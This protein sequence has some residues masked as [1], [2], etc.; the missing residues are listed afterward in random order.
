MRKILFTAS[1]LFLLPLTAMGQDTPG[2]EVFGGFSYLHTEGGGNLYGW[3]G[4][5]NVNLNKWFGLVVDFSGHYDSSSSRSAIIVTPGTSP[6]SF[7][8]DSKENFHT[9]MVGPRFSLRKHDKVTPFSH[10]LFGITRRHF[11]SRTEFPGFP[12]AFSEFNNT[13]FAGVAGAGVDVKMTKSLVLRVIQADYLLTRSFGNFQNNARLS[14]GLVYR[15][16]G[17]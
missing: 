7:R 5:V 14:T 6:V 12:L 16:G 17:N 9:F 11:E 15:F 2:V 8:F 10:L 3:N 4:S 1:M 13:G